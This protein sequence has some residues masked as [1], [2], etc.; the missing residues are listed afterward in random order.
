MVSILLNREYSTDTLKGELS[1]LNIEQVEL[2]QI[3]NPGYN[4]DLVK[5][6]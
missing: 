3:I 4:F 6:S 1:R 5:S 2:T